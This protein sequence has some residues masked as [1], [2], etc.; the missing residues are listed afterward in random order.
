[1][2]SLQQLRA[3]RGLLNWT[4]RQLARAA[5]LSLRTLNSI[6]LGTTV[7][8]LDTMR[9][10]QSAFEAQN[11]VFGPGQALRL[12]DER[13]EIEK[14]EG[15][16]C[17]EILANDIIDQLRGRGGA[18]FGNYPDE[19]ALTRHSPRLWDKFYADCHACGIKDYLLVRDG[20]TDFIAPPSHYRWLPEAVLGK[21]SY[22]IYH[23]TVSFLMMGPSPRLVIIRSATIA[24]HFRVQ[25]TANWDAAIVPPFNRHLVKDEDSARPWTMA[26]ADAMR[27]KIRKMGY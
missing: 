22:S 3:A 16:T 12:L 1:M 26:R 17:V 15:E 5:G 7:P 2:I 18:Y 9:A 8:R 23:D 24:D 13:L 25:L 20:F 19:A 21:L 4:Q 27:K 11:V 14:H 6:E 10:I